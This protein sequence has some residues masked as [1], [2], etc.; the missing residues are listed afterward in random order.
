VSNALAIRV[1]AAFA[2]NSIADAERIHALGRDELARADQ[3]STSTI[4]SE[5]T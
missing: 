1:L 2:G 5:T 3:E 4:A